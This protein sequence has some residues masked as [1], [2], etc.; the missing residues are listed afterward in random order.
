MRIIIF[1]GAGFLGKKLATQLL[2]R[3][4]VSLRGQPAKPITS[5]VLFDKTKADGLSADPRLEILEGDIRDPGSLQTLLKTPADAIFH[6]A[7]IVSGEA[8]KDF[9]LGMQVNLHATLNLLEF[10]RTLQQKPILVFASSCAVFGG[11]LSETI[12]D[13]T[14]PTPRSSYGTQKAMTD[15]LI[16]DYNRRGFI[17]GRALRLP[18]IAV[19]PG[20]PNAATSSFVSSI[21]R[22]PLAGV[23]ANC[24]VAA[25]TKVWILSPRKVTENFIHALELP[26]ADLGTNRIIN[27]PGLTTSVDE[28]VR[29]L[30]EIAGDEATQL[31]DWEPDPFIQSIVLTWPPHFVTQR[32]LDLGF[33]NDKSVAEIIQSHIKEELS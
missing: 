15:L 14:T 30:G 23:S 31:I 9:E 12:Y 28:M 11:E 2:Q 7:A 17:D 10:C 24:P 5:L 3:E 32:G 13:S 20:K 33:K 4:K 16:N 8:E 27:L 21:I 29:N 22:E 19:R 25:D 6:L 18:T 26:A 1:G